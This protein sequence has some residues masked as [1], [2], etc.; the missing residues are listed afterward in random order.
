MQFMRRSGSPILAVSLLIGLAV[1]TVVSIGEGF[2]LFVVRKD[3]IKLR[4]RDGSTITLSMPWNPP[5]WQASAQVKDVN[6]AAKPMLNAIEAV[7]NALLDDGTNMASAAQAQAATLTATIIP[8]AAS[9]TSSVL[10]G[11]AAQIPTA[12]QDVTSA[13]N[14]ATGIVGGVVNAANSIVGSM[15]AGAMSTSNTGILSSEGAVLSNNK[16]ALSGGSSPGSTSESLLSQIQT[17][18]RSSHASA[19]LPYNITSAPPLSSAT[20]KSVLPMAPSCS[21]MPTCTSC[22]APVT[23][24]CTVTET[25]HSTHYDSTATLFSF[26][27]AF[28]VT[29]TETV[30]VC[31]L[32][33]AYLP[34]P[35]T[36]LPKQ[37]SLVACANGV[38]VKRQEDCPPAQTSN[39]I[40]S[41]AKS[42]SIA[43]SYPAGSQT[44]SHPCP[45]A[46]YSCS[47]CPDGWFCPPSQTAPQSGP[48]GFGWACGACIQGWF[49]I[50][51]PTTNGGMGSVN[52][53][54]AVL[55][56]VSMAMTMSV[57]STMASF[58][59]KPPTL[60]SIIPLALATPTGSATVLCIGGSVVQ[61]SQDCLN[62]MAGASA[63]L[64][65]FG[66]PPGGVVSQPTSFAGGAVGGAVITLNPAMGIISSAL[67]QVSGLTGGLLS[68]ILANLAPLL[69]AANSLT[70]NVQPT[71]AIGNAASNLLAEVNA[72]TGTV[73]PQATGAL[74]GNAGNVLS[75]G[76]PVPAATDVVGDIAGVVGTVAANVNTFGGNISPTAT[77][78]MANVV[79][80]ALPG[81]FKEVKEA[82]NAISRIITIVNGQS[83]VLPIVLTVLDGKPT[84][85]PR[86]KMDVNGAPTDMPVLNGGPGQL[87]K[88]FG[89]GGGLKQRRSNLET[90]SYETWLEEADDSP[91]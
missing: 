59:A 73:I 8:V 30:S 44:S 2:K 12:L 68:T 18:L 90:I 85:I 54:T 15:V 39:T 71:S 10:I 60:A 38:L 58:T 6:P 17:A 56:S 64:L 50:P 48:C 79:G 87:A 3:G 46:G 41:S 55:S 4:S 43:S 65:A 28:T 19:A 61:S 76:N 67:A 82:G 47:E 83:T 1:L 21:T 62:G 81:V 74:V 66:T 89:G 31:P 11:G 52:S 91:K 35:N 53:A 36:T 37:P 45:G 5:K 72:L 16:T 13:I 75:G 63:S 88:L 78:A 23:S 80:N 24:T 86:V 42:T 33:I 14:Q 26:V 40:P 34:P 20:S 70:G 84:V 32:P 49:C 25:W 7:A 77:V 29:C 22:P 51:N 69:G 57:P 9:I 27:A